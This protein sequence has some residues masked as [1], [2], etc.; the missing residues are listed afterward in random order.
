[1]TC[2][3]SASQESFQINGGITLC[4]LGDEFD[5]LGLNPEHDGKIMLDVIH[6]ISRNP[7]DTVP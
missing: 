1:M 5:K 7:I 4:I 2:E 6:E 3:L